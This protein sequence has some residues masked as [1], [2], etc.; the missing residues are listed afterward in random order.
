MEFRLMIEALDPIDRRSIDLEGKHWVLSEPFNL[1]RPES[2]PK[3]SCISYVWGDKTEREP[4]PL[5][6]DTTM[7]THTIPAFTAAIRAKKSNAFWIDTFCVPPAEPAKRFT[8]ESMGFIYYQSSEVIVMLSSTT[9]EA[10]EQM[11]ERGMVTE[12]GLA[13]L[14]QDNW[15]TRLWTYQESANANYFYFVYEGA[16][17]IFEPIV[18]VDFFNH[19]GFSLQKLK[20]EKGI[21]DLALT[22]LFPK[23]S[24]LEDL[25]AES[26]V[27]PLGHRSALVVMTSI[28]RRTIDNIKNLF[29]A[30][31]CAVTTK[32]SPGLWNQVDQDPAEVFMA[33]C[34]GN[35]DYSF[36]YSS[37]ER[38][39]TPG[40]RWRPKGHSLSPILSYHS[41]GKAQRAHRTPEGLW[42]EGMLS[43]AVSSTMDAEVRSWIMWWLNQ[44]E[45]VEE[46]DSVLAQACVLRLRGLGLQGFPRDAEINRTPAELAEQVTHNPP[47]YLILKEGIFVPQKPATQ[48]LRIL[49]SNQIFWAFGAPGLVEIEGKEGS[50]YVVG[51]YVGNR[52]GS[53]AQANTISALL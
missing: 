11:V 20:K 12:E 45:L 35:N 49:V 27:T 50:E 3:Y 38:D 19:L 21:D 31:T 43:F 52:V 24:N 13:R 15:A 37:D 2:I 41:Y 51:V 18:G 39:E 8:L 34:E 22:S 26:C 7:S 4:H 36:I 28:Q 16:N 5:L 17:E 30:M 14:E 40:R 10:M 9:S 25:L 42:L 48:I 53:K 47:E 23:L 1:D 46:V 32:P 29:Y 6:T 44:S 33:T